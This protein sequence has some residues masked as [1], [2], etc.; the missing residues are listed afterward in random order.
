MSYASNI[1][2]TFPYDDDREVVAHF[3]AGKRAGRMSADSPLKA[4]N[5][6]LAWNGGVVTTASPGTTVAWFNPTDNALMGK[7]LSGPA[8]HPGVLLIHAITDALGAPEMRVTREL[9]PLEIRAGARRDAPALGFSPDAERH[10][11]FFAGN[12]VQIDQ[13]FL[14]AGPMAI[15]AYRAAMKA[16]PKNLLR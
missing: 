1:R 10:R 2:T 12:P 5:G 13:P 11:F 3:L 15:T 9:E 8:Y 7:L 16:R 4:R 14:L 6:T